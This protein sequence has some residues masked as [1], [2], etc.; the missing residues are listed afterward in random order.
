MYVRSQN[1]YVTRALADALLA[2]LSARPAAALLVVPTVRL[3][4]NDISP[5]PATVVGDFVEATFAGYNDIAEPALAGPI[6]VSPDARGLI[7][8]VNF[9]GGAIVSPGETAF[10]YYVT[11]DTGAT[12]FMYERFADAVPFST[13]G[14]FL[15]LDVVYVEPLTRSVP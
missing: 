11:D 3:F 7:A 14:D 6:S 12:L 2:A 5:N 9:I 15:N 8:T 13:N 1:P 4:V 10:G